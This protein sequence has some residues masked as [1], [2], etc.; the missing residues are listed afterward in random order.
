MMNRAGRVQRD[1]FEAPRFHER[2][3]VEMK[4]LRRQRVVVFALSLTLAIAGCSSQPGEESAKGTAGGSAGSAL[5]NMLPKPS[6]TVPAETSLEVRLTTGLNSKSNAA[7]DTFTASVEKDV[8]VD[9][10]TAIPKG[11]EVTGKVTNAVPSGRLKQR[12]ELSVTLTSVNVGGKPYELSTSTV[13]QKEGSKA[14]RD[15][16]FI[17]GGAGAG[18]GIGAIAGGGKGA[19]IGALIGAGAGTAGAMMTGQKDV[20]FP[21]ESVLRFTLQQEIKIK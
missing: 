5:K 8:L 17:G 9:G 20:K 21:A 7:G 13:G 16:I 15:V 4:F 14:T 19:A 11:A 10:K 2:Q 18:A 1:T 12:A 6:I 3:E